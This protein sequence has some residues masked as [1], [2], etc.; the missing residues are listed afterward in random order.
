MAATSPRSDPAAAAAPIG[1]PLCCLA[2][3]TPP[4]W[5]CGGPAPAGRAA[6]LP[7]APPACG[8]PAAAAGRGPAPGPSLAP[9]PG[10]DPLSRKEGMGPLEASPGPLPARA[11]GPG[12][13]AA[14]PGKAPACGRWGAGAPAGC[15]PPWCACGAAGAAAGG[16]AAPWLPKPALGVRLSGGWVGGER[17]VGVA[18]GLGP[19]AC[20]VAGIARGGGGPYCGGGGS[21]D[22]AALPVEGRRSRGPPWLWPPPPLPCCAAA[23]GGGAWWGWLLLSGWGEGEGWGVPDVPPPAAAAAA[24]AAAA[25]RAR[26]FWSLSR[27]CCWLEAAL[28][29]VTAGGAAAWL[30]VRAAPSALGRVASRV[31]VVVTVGWEAAAG[32]GSAAGGGWSRCSSCRALQPVMHVVARCGVSGSWLA[33]CFSEVQRRVLLQTRA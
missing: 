5:P 3:G 33:V 28:G 24:A 27:C 19:P 16:R 25:V 30:G 2:S 12:G 13:P 26:W 22:V 17:G 18:V 15:A 11:R 7:C 29:E 20:L 21:G 4:L 9:P 1:P 31:T 8:G 14:L 32:P 23:A 10:L 6:P